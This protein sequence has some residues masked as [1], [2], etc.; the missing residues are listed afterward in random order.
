MLLPAWVSV[1]TRSSVPDSI[2][3]QLLPFHLAMFFAGL[4]PAVP[5][6]PPAYRFVPDTNNEYTSLLVPEPNAVHVLP[7]HFAMR[8]AVLPPAVVNIPP[9]YTLVPDTASA[10]TMLFIP[11]PSGD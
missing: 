5:K 4:P 11:E 7:F 10:H 9:A 8:L 2:A 1:C 3:D 6:K